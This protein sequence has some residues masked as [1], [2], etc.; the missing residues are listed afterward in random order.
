MLKALAAPRVEPSFITN[1]VD[2]MIKVPDAASYASIHFLKKVLGRRCGGSTG[3]NLYG[4]FQ[5]MAEMQKS[6][7]SGSVVTLICDPGDRYMHTYYN[8]MWLLENGFDIQPYY[9]QLEHF[10]TSGEWR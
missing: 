7:V 4:T 9:D 8:N 2:R 5:I 10:Y 6:G 1:V 3:T